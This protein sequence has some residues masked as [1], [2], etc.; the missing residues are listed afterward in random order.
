[1][2]RQVSQWLDLLDG[3]GGSHYMSQCRLRLSADARVECCNRNKPNSATQ[4]SPDSRLASTIAFLASPSTAQ[5]QHSNSTATAQ[6]TTLLSLS[7]LSLSFLTA[8]CSHC[9]VHSQTITITLYRHTLADNDETANHSR[10]GLAL[11]VGSKCQWSTSQTWLLGS[12]SANTGSVWP[13][14]P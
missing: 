6:H 4:D 11:Q 13:S 9:Q 12:R 5:Q 10:Q 2:E 8:H 7:L 3:L 1:M 14:P